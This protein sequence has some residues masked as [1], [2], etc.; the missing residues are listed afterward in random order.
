MINW[1]RDI[2][3]AVSTVAHGMWVTLRYWFRT[4]EP[5][6]GTFTHKFE[7]PERPVPVAARYRGF[8]RYDLTTCIAC[9]QCAKACPVEVLC[10]GA[11]VMHRYNPRPIEIGR[12][13]RHAMDY[14][15]ASGRRLS[16]APATKSGRVACI[17]AGP[18]SL[19]CAASLRQRRN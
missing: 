3:D 13:Q 5:E 17:G 15:Y 14:F 18:A 6:R 8:H 2:W 16:A 12:L 1:L 10:E 4:Y 7:Y 11:C 9:D 19:A